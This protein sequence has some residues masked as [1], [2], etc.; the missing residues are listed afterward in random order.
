MEHAVIEAILIGLALFFVMA[1]LGI[2]LWVLLS[3]A[4]YGDD[5]H[6]DIKQPPRGRK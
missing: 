6:T 3:P 2:G 1:V 4:I 5:E